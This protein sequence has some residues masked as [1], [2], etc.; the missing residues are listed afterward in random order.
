VISAYGSLLFNE[1]RMHKILPKAASAACSSCGSTVP[2][3]SASYCI[4]VVCN[5]KAR[6]SSLIVIDIDWVR[7]PKFEVIPVQLYSGTKQIGLL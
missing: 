3:L 2:D 7:S 6:K 5:A 4:N 1:T